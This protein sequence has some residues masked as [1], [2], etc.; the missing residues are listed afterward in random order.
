MK[1]PR[2]GLWLLLWGLAFGCPTAIKGAESSITVRPDNKTVPLK[3]AQTLPE[4][5]L[6]GY[7]K[8][9]AQYWTATDASL[10]DVVCQDEE[11]AKL[12]QAKF[13]SDLVSLPGVNKV[14]IGSGGMSTA[15]E[16]KDQ[17]LVAA[18][19]FRAH[20][21]LVTSS[22]RQGL[23]QLENEALAGDK[24]RLSSTAEAEVPM[25]LDRWDKYG[26]RFYYGPFKR[27]PGPDGRDVATYDPSQDFEFAKEMDHS[28]LVLWLGPNPT[29]TAEGITNM[30]GT[31]WVL[32][33]AQKA[34]LPVG[35]NGVVAETYWLFNHSP[36]QMLQYQ[37][38]F[39]GDYYGSMNF[40]GAELAGW[41]SP[42]AQDLEL[43]QWQHGIEYLKTYPNITS[44][45]EP[46]G[47]MGH[48][49][50]D[51]LVEYGPV[52]DRGYQQYL[53]LKYKTVQGL[54][55]AWGTAYAKWG[56]VRVPELASFCGW[57]N[58]AID[59]TGKWRM[60][61]DA[62]YGA[63]SATVNLDDSG[64]AE[65]EAP[66]HG[67]ARLFP[68]K[69][70]VWRRHFTMDKGWL[71]THR[72][73]WLYVW[74]LNDTRSRAPKNDVEVFLN[75]KPAPEKPPVNSV[76]HHVALEVS[77]LLLADKNLLTVCL[78]KG[79]FNYRVYLTPEEPRNYPNLGPG[80]N[81]Q[82][83]DFVDWNAWCRAEVVK[84]GMQAIR[85]KDPDRPIDLMSPGSYAS[86][87]KESAEHYGG[88]FKN[89]GY[90]GAFW[91]DSL[92]M[93]MRSSGK[94]F[95]AEPGGPAKNL[96]EFKHALGLWHT[97]GLQG[98]DYFIHLGSILWIPEIRQ[99]FEQTL[100]IIKLI[101]KYHV[102]KAEV[103]FL[104]TTGNRALSDFPW[105][106]DPNV[107]LPSNWNCKGL[108]DSL[109]PLYPRD[110]ITE[111]DF[112]R[113]NATKYKVIIDT[114]T[115]VLEADELAQIEK[116]VRD[117][118]TFVTF[119]QTGRHSAGVPDSWPIARLTG[120]QV[121]TV[122]KFDADG[123]TIGKFKPGDPHAGSP[124]QPVKPAPNQTIYP[125][126]EDWMKGNFLTGLRLKK[127]APDAQDLLLWQ[128]GTVAAGLRK[129]GKGCIIQL[130]C[131]N[132]GS[133][134]LGLAPEAITR[135]LDWQGVRQV[136][137]HLEADAKTSPADLKQVISRQYLSN[138]GLDDVWA[139]W[140]QSDKQ[141]FTV[142]LNLKS[143]A[144]QVAW[145]VLG[146]VELP[147]KDG[148]LSGLVLEPLQ[149]RYFLMPHGA[150]NEA[151]LAWLDLQRNWWAGTE[152]TGKPVPEFKP[153]LA[154]E[155]TDDWAFKPLADAD[156]AA[157]LADPKLSD[158]GWKRMRLGIFSLPDYP[159]VHHA[160]FRKRVT[161][162]S[163][164][165]HGLVTLWIQS[166]NGGTFMDKGRV[167]LDG[168][169]LQDTSTNG[170]SGLDAG[171]AF[172]AGSS[173]LVAI[174]VM[175]QNGPVG[176]RG[177]AWFAYH[178]APDGTQD[179]AG[180]WQVSPD[181]MRYPTTIKLPGDA[182]GL[183]LRR[184]V[185]IDKAQASRTVVLHGT[186]GS[187][188]MRSVIIN[189]HW[190]D[191]F[192]HRIGNEFDLNITPWVKFGAPNE[193]ILT[194]SG[195]KFTLQEF[196]LEFHAKGTY[197]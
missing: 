83:V 53:T 152:N 99:H 105:Q 24:T 29:S 125:Q 48:G 77:S 62:P 71:A 78:P 88:N 182:N 11:K 178:P 58:E 133:V 27:P 159:D 119:A 137:G 66:G 60:S 44:W 171:G 51:L 36:E 154:R 142:S 109:L 172:K 185:S 46:H 87:I 21:L 170:I 149:T 89:T 82:W 1:L 103:A 128:D 177:E 162:P 151:P 188:W 195:G 184:V 3:L 28:G 126:M 65:V 23:Q 26:F 2:V 14:E 39:L 146:K 139:I 168:K 35:A 17:G 72:R 19:R 115:S 107:I 158:S 42:E 50:A 32:R 97:E 64:W 92:P 157:P 34:G 136:D 196:S 30:V 18:L 54:N 94:P 130:G 37:P 47:E 153:K 68:Q 80:T 85:Q 45:L 13:L 106:A 91:A 31:D 123:H 144:P 165:N 192:R 118:G 186:A 150:I 57:G 121:L 181:G 79:L 4:I 155:L 8:L 98:I 194:G 38:Q 25:W 173:H 148:K 86:G 22:S 116:Y 110:A 33:A 90:M 156:Q 108:A 111:G 96:A 164:W 43:A 197:P 93:M 124:C 179:L 187:N 102:P 5:A 15:W 74:D 141:T 69:P 75:G 52:A 131:K 117:G 191:R 161:V 135:I 7:G 112:A 76:N 55:T 16:V 134:W 56:D 176:V 189:G 20:V 175:G 167:F 59:L 160:V 10:L 6:R 67:L 61:Y 101:G 120:Y 166:W 169:L 113:G 40:G 9:K 122:E 81:T 129:L 163:E 147:V 84:R 174:E 132:D 104:W 183:V 145:D 193:I 180:D 63:A 12:L 114:N 95:T 143:P 73:V 190:V 41:N 127:V 100:P 138:N 49:V 140:N 70:A